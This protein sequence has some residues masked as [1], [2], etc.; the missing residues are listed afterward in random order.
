MDFN[1]KYLIYVVEDDKLYNH[2]ITEYL[3]KKNYTNVKS[4]FS[5]DECIQS[6]LNK[7]IPDIIIQDYFMDDMNGLQVLQKVKKICPTSEF[8]FLTANESIEVAISTM[9]TGAYDYIIKDSVA[10]D[11]VVNK[12]QK[13]VK[14]LEL[15]KNNRQI[16]LFVRLFLS[17]VFI[18]IVLSFLY[19]VVDIF[20]VN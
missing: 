14:I 12:I 8:I 9:K 18:L 10:L 20:N 6:I 13:I 2:L 17:A 5:G 15:E 19:F 11:K 7:E 16:R 3:K 4:F 1:E